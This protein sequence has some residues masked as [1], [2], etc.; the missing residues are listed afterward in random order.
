MR[1][2]VP[3][4][5]RRRQDRQRLCVCFCVHTQSGRPRV[6]ICCGVL[7]LSLYT[8][9][10]P[11]FLSPIHLC[12]HE[13]AMHIRTYTSALEVCRRPRLTF[14]YICKCSTYMDISFFLL[15]KLFLLLFFARYL[16]YLLVDNIVICEALLHWCS[17][18]H[19]IYTL[20]EWGQR[21]TSIYSFGDRFEG[22]REGYAAEI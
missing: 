10:H 21:K 14:V 13:D 2:C 5:S 18:L 9:T 16:F 15:R 8:V 6:Q 3:E 12:T 11:L 20:E 1:Q 19:N 22:W 7:L 17:Y 4:Q